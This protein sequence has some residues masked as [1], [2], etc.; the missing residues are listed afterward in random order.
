MIAASDLPNCDHHLNGNEA[1][2][3]PLPVFCVQVATVVWFRRV[4]IAHASPH[5]VMHSFCDPPSHHTRLRDIALPR[6]KHSSYAERNQT[7]SP[8]CASPFLQKYGRVR[9]VIAPLGDWFLSLGYCCYAT[10]TAIERYCAIATAL[11]IEK[12]TWDRT[13]H[14]H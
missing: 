11:R 2:H 14:V 7:T 10:A 13:G 8:C 9:S 4:K 12:W 5:S 6:L 1:L 3:L